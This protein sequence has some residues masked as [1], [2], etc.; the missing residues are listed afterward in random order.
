MYPHLLQVQATLEISDV[1]GFDLQPCWAERDIPNIGYT[2]VPYRSKKLRVV[3]L[4]KLVGSEGIGGAGEDVSGI[5]TTISSKTGDVCSFS[6]EASTGHDTLDLG[7]L[8]VRLA[9]QR[10]GCSSL[11]SLYP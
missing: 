2:I 8:P 1:T 5:S 9:V 6:L 7:E 10:G 3:V 4:G 11:V